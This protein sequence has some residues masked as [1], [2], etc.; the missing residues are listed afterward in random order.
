MTFTPDPACGA[1]SGKNGPTSRRNHP[2]CQEITIPMCEKIG[3]NMT[4]MP[5]QFNHETQ[6]EAGLEVS[7]FGQSTM[8]LEYSVVYFDQNT[9]SLSHSVVYFDQN[10]MSLSHSVVYFDQNTMSL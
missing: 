10:T 4:Y 5:N 9:M 7:A 3:Y 8:S 2:K 1:G 6:E